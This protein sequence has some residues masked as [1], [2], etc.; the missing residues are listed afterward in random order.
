VE[1]LV[2]CFELAAEAPQAKGRT[3]IAGDDRA[4]TLTELVQ[5][6]GTAVGKD[7]RIVRFPWYDAAWA[8]AAVIEA[9][10]K[11]ARVKPPVF[12]RRLSWFKTNRWFSIDR[13]RTEL[14]YEPRVS[15][16]DGLAKTAAWYRNKGYLDGVAMCFA[17]A[18]NALVCW[19][20]TA[21]KCAHCLE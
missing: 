5:S 17:V 9:T 8:S 3:Y 11:R 14:G 18:L 13:A 15:L 16:S 7:V 12:R 2:D 21:E 6:V 1:N 19:A 4:V 20:A 10:F